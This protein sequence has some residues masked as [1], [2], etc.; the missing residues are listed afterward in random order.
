M[1]FEKTTML[2]HALALAAMGFEVF[3]LQPNGK[4]PVISKYPE[5][6]TTDPEQIRKWWETDPLRNIGVSSSRF[7]GRALFITDVDIKEGR[8]GRETLL[9]LEL[10]GYE[11][12]STFTVRTGSGGIHYY[13]VVDHPMKQ[14][15]DV[16][17]PGVDTR[18]KGGYVVGPGSVVN[19]KAY[20]IEDA[21]AP[22]DAPAWMLEFTKKAPEGEAKAGERLD[23][24]DP[25]RARK[26]AIEWLK[27]YAPAGTAGNRNNTGF[28]VAAKLK[29]FGCDKEE[30]LELMEEHWDCS[31]AASTEDLEKIIA[32][33]FK[34]A[35]E[36][37]GSAAPEA[38]FSKVGKDAP[39]DEPGEK[40]DHAKAENETEDSGGGGDDG[41]DADEA[42]DED[43]PGE[44]REE[45]NKKY[46]YVKEGNFILEE[47]IRHG[48]HRFRR[49]SYDNFTLALANHTQESNGRVIKL[50]KLW[51][52]W[53][54]RREYDCMTFKP[55]KEAES[56]EYNIWRGFA[57]EPAANW[58]HPA[59]EKLLD[60]ILKNACGGDEKLA[61]WFVGYLAHMVQRPWE[62][63]RVAL[64]FKG[65]KGVGKTIIGEIMSMLFP[66]HAVIADEPRYLVGNFN[67]HFEGCLLFVADEASWGG[68]KRHEGKL[69]GL[70][71]GKTHNIE[72]KGFEVY[73][74]ENLTRII[75]IGNEDWLVPASEDERR[76]GVFNFSNGKKQND[77]FFGEIMDGMRSDGLAAWL[78]YLLDYDM[79][80]IDVN[81]APLTEGLLQQK[82]ATLGPVK[83][84]W[85]DCLNEDSLLGG[86]MSP[87]PERIPT[88]RLE[89]A[90]STWA[91]EQGKN[92][93]LPTKTE[94]RKQLA[95]MAPSLKIDYDNRQREPGDAKR[96]FYNPGLD[97]LRRE[98]AAFLQ[99]DI[100]WRD[101]GGVTFH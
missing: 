56:N 93:Y 31:P 6:A 74:V 75:I 27:K 37:Q 38:V 5:R 53:R 62:K 87:L 19:G 101:L 50:S 22:V 81:K 95:D 15:V 40:K 52:E 84:W 54:H 91:K 48:R 60:H 64:V 99:Q 47:Y 18:S 3:P 58:K 41:I 39:K 13:H 65:G 14:G 7:K 10:Q 17:G 70:I 12:T 26:R 55:C 86:A 32:N 98:F 76:Y 78:R 23:G 88:N 21:R 68:D 67:G 30:T 82:I 83:S 69:K 49:L 35:R 9:G 57:V 59:V 72:R 73:V 2:D 80:G 24:I 11:V 94:L 25:V 20:V 46:A 100:N 42:P 28:F 36:A 51:M 34:Y 29:D 97:V 1:S 77:A 8:D 96:S 85:L 16:F 66:E 45:M 33:A 63:P 79:K 89:G 90:F 43:E 44:P 71:T 4:M 92:R 61:A